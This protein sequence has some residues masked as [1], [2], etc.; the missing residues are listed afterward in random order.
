MLR[1]RELEKKYDVGEIFIKLEGQNPTG[2]KYDRVAEV[3]IKDMIAHGL[4]KVVVDGSASYIKSLICFAEQAEL[5]VYIPWFKN[6]RWKKS[7]FSE[8]NFI[9]YRNEKFESKTNFLM[10]QMNDMEYYLAIEGKTNTHISQMVLEQLSDELLHQMKFNVDTVFTQLR[11]GYTLTSIYNSLLKKWMNGNIEK[12]PSIS[13]GTWENGNQIYNYYI[14][15]NKVK[16]SMIEAIDEEYTHRNSGYLDKRLL[17]ESMRAVLETNGG[18]VSIEDE[19]LKNAS[20]LLNKLEHIK[21]NYQEAYAIAAFIKLAEADE[22]KHGRHVIVL[23]DGKS[24]VKI[25]DVEDFNEIS[26]DTLVDFT[27]TWLAQYSDSALETEEAIQ[28]AMDKGYI[29]LASRN[30]EYEGIC[31]I[32]NLGFDEFIPMY[33]LA[34]IGTNSNSKGRGVGSELIKHAI[35]LT[36]GNIS[37]H[38]DLDNKGAKKLY[39]KYGFKHVYNRMIYY[40]E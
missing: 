39:E 18:I 4:K 22:I 35:D 23:N 34:Y 8:C 10:S 19:E 2:H 3:L 29:M 30:G 17:E 13:C 26:K 5:E 7:K 21:V 9:D 25:D 31:I 32:V 12:F 38:V 16:T 14:E 37:L 27:R 24:V 20:R 6:E 15:Y 28:N 33:H 1:A 11:Y 36:D 40:G